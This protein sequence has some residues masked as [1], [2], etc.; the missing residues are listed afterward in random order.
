MI[1]IYLKSYHTYRHVQLPFS[2]S[3]DKGNLESNLP[4]Y[5]YC[6][7]LMQANSINRVIHSSHFQLLF[8][9]F[10]FH[11]SFSFSRITMKM[12]EKWSQKGDFLLSFS[13]SF[14]DGQSKLRWYCSLPAW[15]FTSPHT[16]QV[17]MTMA[18]SCGSNIN[19]NKHTTT[20][21][22][23]TSTS[24]WPQ[25]QPDHHDHTNY[26]MVM[27]P[28]HHNKAR[29]DG[30][31]RDN[32]HQMSQ[33]LGIVSWAHCIFFTCF[34]SI[35]YWFIECLLGNKQQPAETTS[36]M[37]TMPPVSTNSWLKWCS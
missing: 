25:Q 31:G 14:L 19:N 1:Y 2:K 4:W 6:E 37:P 28:R 22:N 24:Q 30:Q 36:T 21:N 15:C 29:N 8:G 11:F 18:S 23:D 26:T 27:K 5:K 33:G 3:K 17:T 13:F 32:N 7:G 16:L 20:M 34:C 10:S 12:T 9:S 35:F